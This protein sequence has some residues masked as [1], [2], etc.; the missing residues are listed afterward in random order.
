MSLSFRPPLFLLSALGW[1]LLSSLLGLGLLLA[2]IQGRAVPTELRIA[3]VHSALI[4]GVAQMIL[5]AMLAFIPA[6]LMTGRDTSNSHP[7]LYLAI[8]VGT[9]GML[10]GFWLTQSYVV[11]GFG[12]LVVLAFLSLLG[13][14]IQ[15]TR[16]SLIAPPLNLWFYGV[17]LLLLLIGLGLGEAIAW[18]LVSQWQVAKARMAHIHLNLIGFVILTIVG[19]MHNLFP[20]ILESRLHSPRLARLVFFILPAG[21]LVLVAGFVLAHLYVQIAGGILLL[22]GT[23][24]Y[25]Y[26]MTRTWMDAGRPTTTAANHLM[27]ATVFLLLAV[28]A[29]ILVSVNALWDPPAI[30]FGTLHLMAYTHLALVGFVLQTILGALTHLLP[31]ILA[32]ARVKANKKRGPYFESLTA[33][34]ERW[35]PVQVGAFNLG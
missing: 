20:T 21:V 12:L 33:L 10:V 17:A 7:V 32:V 27:M 29:G 6:L 22:L 23:S 4:G 25:A 14:G 28:I 34:M 9:L 31:V 30:P 18:E 8:N 26:N 16:S 13:R 24:L 19:T 2:G 11:G 3:H 15:E 1:L 5:G 35:Q